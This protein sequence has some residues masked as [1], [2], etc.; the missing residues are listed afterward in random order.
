MN[1][2]DFEEKADG[3][4]AMI[5]AKTILSEDLAFKLK[6]AYSQGTKDLADFLADNNLLE[7][8]YNLKRKT[9]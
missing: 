9:K 7:S 1:K 3:F 6:A 8:S 5:M 4:I 2:F